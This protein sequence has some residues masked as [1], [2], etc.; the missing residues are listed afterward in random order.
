MIRISKIIC[1]LHPETPI[2]LPD[3]KGCMG[4]KQ[5]PKGLQRAAGFGSYELRATTWGSITEVWTLLQSYAAAT[6]Q[7]CTPDHPGTE[8]YVHTWY[9]VPGSSQIY[10]YNCL[11]PKALPYDYTSLLAWRACNASVALDGAADIGRV[12]K[13]LGDVV[14]GPGEYTQRSKRE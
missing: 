12:T 7:V 9:Q 5:G 3:M 13:D 6:C 2:R 8:W 11:T 4:R 1:T 14:G 10:A